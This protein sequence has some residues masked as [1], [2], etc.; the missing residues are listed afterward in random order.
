MHYIQ[1]LS[2]LACAQIAIANPVSLEVRAKGAA[3]SNSQSSEAPKSSQNSTSTNKEVTK[4]SVARA[5]DNFA[6]DAGIVSNAINKMTS[7]TDQNAIKVTAQRAFDAESD[8]DNQRRILVAAAG[9]AGDSANGKIMKFTPTV[10][11]GLD[12]IT[13]DPSPESVMKNTKTM[14]DARNAN[15]LPSI[16]ELS[17]AALG[18]MGLDQ[19]APKIASTNGAS[20]NGNTGNTDN[21]GNT[22][23]T[24]NNSNN[25]GNNDNNGS[26]TSSALA[27]AMKTMKIMAKPAKPAIT[28]AAPAPAATMTMM[29]IAAKTA[30]APTAP[31]PALA[32]I[33][34]K[35]IT[36]PTARIIKIAKVMLI[37]DNKYTIFT[38]KNTILTTKRLD[39]IILRF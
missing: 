24:G 9:S 34:I 16:T 6:Q 26:N 3:S 33:A 7:M 15:I 19:T 1:I 17:N 20:G 31:G 38:M 10:L 11:D 37:W 23:N 35:L 39:E 14:E 13:K 36:I 27:L 29:K 5:A 25:S 30:P 18:A 12:A 21:T 22:G 28:A 8:E 32:K 2:L 4:D